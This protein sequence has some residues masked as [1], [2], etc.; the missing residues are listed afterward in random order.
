MENRMLAGVV[1]AVVVGLAGCNERDADSFIENRHDNDQ[2]VMHVDLV[3]RSEENKTRY[4]AADQISATG[5]EELWVRVELKETNFGIFVVADDDDQLQVDYCGSQYFIGDNLVYDDGDPEYYELVVPPTY[6]NCEMKVSFFHAKERTLTFNVPTFLE[7]YVSDSDV[8]S[9]D[10]TEEPL[11]VS[12]R[13]LDRDAEFEFRWTMDASVCPLDA[14]CER[15]FTRD[16]D[17][18][19]L[20]YTVPANLFDVADGEMEKLVISLVQPRY[21]LERDRYGLHKESDVE[22]DQKASLGYR[23]VNP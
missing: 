14:P 3:Y 17:K 12:W 7:L 9:Y 16:M 13:T 5:S 20:G 23:I 2:F 6:D 10:H 18:D 15:E 11:N 21:D 4:I 22:L 8:W 1:L 19:A